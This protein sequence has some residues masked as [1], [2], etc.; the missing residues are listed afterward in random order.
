MTFA[1]IRFDFSIMRTL[2][3]HPCFALVTGNQKEAL[4]QAL[5]HLSAKETLPE[6][7]H[8]R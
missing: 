6:H 3:L 2:S 8:R 7:P 4:A 1:K 5:H